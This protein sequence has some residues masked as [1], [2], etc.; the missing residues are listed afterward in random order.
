MA[1][2][3]GGDDAVVRPGGAGG[4]VHDAGSEADA[5]AGGQEAAADAT[6]A[7]GQCGL[8]A[9]DADCPSGFK[10]IA[11]PLGD[12]FCA[13][14]CSTAACGPSYECVELS[15]YGRPDA[16]ADAAGD[17]GSGG[18][19]GGASEDGGEEAGLEDGEAPE[20]SAGSS[21][22]GAGG[23]STGG[24]AGQAGAPGSGGSAPSTG[25]ACVPKGGESC[26]CVL[27]RTGARRSCT[28]ANEFG[29]C[30]GEETCTA[31][32]W[33]GCDALSAGKEV[34]D[35]K[36]TNCNGFIDMDEPGV[37]GNQLCASGTAPP[38]SGFTCMGGVCELSGCEPGWSKYPASTPPSEGCNCPIDP[39]DITAI[40][41]EVC[42]NATDKQSL[43][44]VASTP[45]ILQATLSSDSDVD[46]YSIVMKDN[47]EVPLPNS[48][49][50]HVEFAEPD[51]NPD[52]HF[53]FDLVRSD[54]VKPCDT[55]SLKTDLTSYDWCAD[56][57]TY[58]TQPANADSTATYRIKVYRKEGVVGDCRPYKLKLSNGGGG[59]ACPADDGCGQ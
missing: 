6:P 48:Y 4:S 28:R 17:A 16:G 53:R 42:E 59:G 7:S 44:D 24:A 35:G 11:A 31:N 1:A 32:A 56:S 2:S 26:P 34:C 12:K 13:Q 18:A 20:A 27:E 10:C 54:G 23:S 38:H 51:G 39:P 40:K 29:T 25:K 15:S 37:T 30:P 9:K 49:R 45:V 19:A 36:D 46:W 47:N 14:D 3:C 21:A 5:G 22:G 41:N 50:V 52:D 8:C 43:G 57:T 58:P 33:Q 55:L